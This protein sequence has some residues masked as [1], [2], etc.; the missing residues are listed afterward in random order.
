MIGSFVLS[1]NGGMDHLGIV[2]DKFDFFHHYVRW[3]DGRD[4]TV[5]SNSDIKSMVRYYEQEL[6]K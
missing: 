5:H 2:V 1:Y 3:F 4:M 6:G